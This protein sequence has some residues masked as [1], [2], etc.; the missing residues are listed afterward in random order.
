MVASQD[1]FLDSK[2][3]PAPKMYAYGLEPLRAIWNDDLKLDLKLNYY[4]KRYGNCRF[5]LNAALLYQA[6][7]L[8]KKRHFT[9]SQAF[10]QKNTLIFNQAVAN[11][12]LDDFYYCLEFLKDNKER[13]ITHLNKQINVKNERDISTVY[14]DILE[15]EFPEAEYEEESL[16]SVIIFMDDLGYPLDFEIYDGADDEFETLKASLE[17]LKSQYKITEAL[18]IQDCE[19]E[20]D[21]DDLESY[22][23]LKESICF[24]KACLS[25]EE[26]TVAQFQGRILLSMMTLLCLRCLDDRLESHDYLLDQKRIIKALNKAFVAPFSQGSELYFLKL[27]GEE[28]FYVDPDPKFSYQVTLDEDEALDLDK[29]MQVSK[30]KPLDNVNTSDN[31]RSCFTRNLYDEILPKKLLESL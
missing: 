9:I 30:L 2:L 4:K 10:S 13:L 17:R 6:F 31:L 12:S 24:F 5:D 23:P 20:N 3:K 25:T 27:E 1:R 26:M 22:D 14:Y 29:I 28:K 21:A 16:I 7:M 19:L 11:L 15:F 8:L 18:D